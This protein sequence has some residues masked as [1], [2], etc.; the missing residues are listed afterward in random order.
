MILRLAGCVPADSVT[1]WH[2]TAITGPL[3]M[4]V[5]GGKAALVRAAAD[6]AL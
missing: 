6:V 4:S 2:T 3:T 1:C 5:L